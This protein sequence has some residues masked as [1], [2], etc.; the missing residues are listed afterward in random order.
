MSKRP[1]LPK[2]YYLILGLILLAASIGLYYGWRLFWFLN[3]DAFIAFRYVGNS[4]L[5]FGYTWNLPPFRP[6]EGYTSFL[7]V[8]LLDLVWR[9]TGVQPPESANV[10]ALIF[11][12]GTTLL[13]AAMILRMRLTPALQR[14]RLPLLAIVLAGVLTNRTYLAWA[15]SGL[16]TAMFNFFVTGWVYSSLFLA[17]NTS[18]WLGWMAVTAILTGLTRPDG[19]L[20]IA[21]TLFLGLLHLLGHYKADRFRF[22]LL[23]PFAPFLATVAHF[24]W[25]RFTY[26]EWLPNTHFAKYVAPWP[27]SGARYLLSFVIEYAL[28]FW[29]ALLLVFLV[30]G[31][32]SLLRRTPLISRLQAWLHDP[33]PA[34]PLIALTVIGALAAHFGY[35]TLIIGGDLLEYRVYSHLVLLIFVSAVWMLN[36]LN[37]NPLRAL[38][39]LG[40]FVLCALP[41]QWTHWVATRDL[42]SREDTYLMR[43]PI[44][45]WFPRAIRPYVQVFDNVQNWLIGHYVGNR[46]Q[47]HKAF[48]LY[49]I[50]YYPP[51]SR[52]ILL[53]E[54]SDPVVVAGP[55]GVPAWVL[56]TTNIIDWYGLNDSVIARNPVDPARFRRMAHDRYPPAGYVPCFQPNLKLVAANKFVVAR[57]NVPA[58]ALIAACEN[59]IWPPNAGDVGTTDLISNLEISSNN[60]PMVDFYLWNVWPPDPLY[61][62]YVPLEQDATALNADMLAAF[63]NYTGLGCIA[64]PPAEQLA[65]RENGQ[66]PPYLFAFL[67][68]AERPPL[69]ELAGP[70]PWT[71]IVTER[72]QEVPITYNL[73]YAAPAGLEA[74]PQPSHPLTA[75]WGNGISLLGYDL[76]RTHYRPG[77]RITLTLYYHVDGPI[78]SDYSAFAHLIGSAVNPA[79][80]SPLW[81]Q[82]D[83]APCRG[84]LL[85]MP[86]W[87]PGSAIVSKM[88]IPISPDVPS[89]DYDLTV[90]FYTWQ[91]GERV[92]LSG[93]MAGQ[94]SVKLE[95]IAI[96]ADG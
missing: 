82:D 74:W 1:T 43:V 18:R 33:R 81:G 8:V 20:F 75:T 32:R 90:G 54:S 29:L 78:G 42:Y 93:A 95:T 13:G 31:L 84:D 66:P 96:G 45:S 16:E 53:S 5:G 7:W 64:I 26:G 19:I 61:M 68:A 23:A 79:N 3:D 21:A 62:Y 34:Q 85:P 28:W 83:G 47:E 51:R 77:E 6:V 67:P 22:C 86:Y 70:F 50:D 91:T 94:D 49:Q 48:Y 56:P 41:I 89:G 80:A 58:D 59:R 57:R 60:A 88:S 65:R 76:P 71:Q 30:I 55:V 11:A 46:H 25:R 9:I 39:F 2:P 63:P 40:V 37:A 24:L 87:Q 92:P 38:A 14:V 17:P 36:R 52:G 72:R 35:Y 73:G 44:A 69:D 10:I 12:Y 15:S 27:E 4:I